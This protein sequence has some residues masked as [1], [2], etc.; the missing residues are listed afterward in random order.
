VASVLNGT[1]AQFGVGYDGAV[2]LIPGQAY[3]PNG[4]EMKTPYSGDRA[5]TTPKAATKVNGK[6]SDLKA[7]LLSSDTGGGFTYYKLRDLGKVLG[8]N[9]GWS[10]DKGVFIETNKPYEG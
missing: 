3:T 6:A 4:S 8:F 7:I 1:K 5:Y 2:N 9:V 10:K